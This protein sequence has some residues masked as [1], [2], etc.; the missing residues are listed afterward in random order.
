MSTEDLAVGIDDIKAAARAIEGVVLRTPQTPAPRLSQATGAT[1]IVKHENMQATAS[2]KERGAV[3]KLLSLLPDERARGVVAMSA[4]NHAQ[5]LAYH[6]RRLGI[7]ATIIM[8]EGTPLVK[9]ENTKAEGAKIV[10]HGATLADAEVEARRLVERDGLVLVHPYDDPRII[11]GQGTIGLEMIE[12]APDLDVLVV[13]IGGGGLCGGIALA[14]KSLKPDIEIIGVEAAL[15]PSMHNAVDGAGMPVGGATLAEGIAVKNV[16]GLTVPLIRHFVSKILVVSET[17]IERAVY[18]FANL[19]RSLAEGAGAAGLAAVMENRGLFAGRRVGLVLCGGN[20]DARILSAI[21]IREL[22]RQERIVSI[23]IT[24]DDRP[25]LLGSIASRLGQLGANILEVRHERLF[26]DV[27]AKGVTIDLTIE[28]RDND[29]S[30]HVLAALEAD[31]L[32]PRRVGARGVE[33]S[34]A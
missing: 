11:A 16:G 23:R 7:P 15:Y 27:P 17:A 21:M 29:H 31:G 33:A 5:A 25:G 19:H 8:P 18:A 24:T 10:L 26:L 12:D 28:A 6:A 34:T 20:I 30:R 32:A 9:I 2:F 3:N 13:P 1:I 22:E 4:G 14:A